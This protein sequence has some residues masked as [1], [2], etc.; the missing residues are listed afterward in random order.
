M[1]LPQYAL[2][3]SPI[4]QCLSNRELPDP[5]SQ[6]RTA[7]RLPQ[8]PIELLAASASAQ[9][10]TTNKRESPRLHTLLTDDDGETV[11]RECSALTRLSTQFFASSRFLLRKLPPIAHLLSLVNDATG[12][13]AR[14]RKQQQTCQPLVLLGEDREEC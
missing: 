5:W 13:A 6:R 2:W 11:A 14:V 1:T 7:L 8:I 4:V 10:T 3:G 12:G 9:T